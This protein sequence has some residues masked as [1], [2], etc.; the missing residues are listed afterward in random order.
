MCVCVCVWVYSTRTHN[1]H[2]RQ[3][4]FSIMKYIWRKS[5]LLIVKP[6]AD[7]WFVK[8]DKLDYSSF[9]STVGGPPHS[10][11]LQPRFHQIF[12]WKPQKNMTDSHNKVSQALKLDFSRMPCGSFL[13]LFTDWYY[14]LRSS[15]A[16][17]ISEAHS[18]Y[19]TACLLSLR[20]KLNYMQF[21]ELHSIF[22]PDPAEWA[23]E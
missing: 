22:K 1:K 14:L 7:W 16:C 3:L 8:S 17:T 19:L 10:S 21:I 11:K 6:A 12:L 13:H 20:Q 9:I 18:L 2:Y 5:S 4:K 15:S 23:S